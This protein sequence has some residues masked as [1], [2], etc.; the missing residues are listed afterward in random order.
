MTKKLLLAAAA[1]GAMAFAGAATAGSIT[2]GAISGVNITS[3]SGATLKSTP[4]TVATEADMAAAGISTPA[5]AVNVVVGLDS[6]VNLAAGAKVPFA[7]TFTL[8]GPATFEGTLTQA[9]L[10]AANGATAATGLV[11]MSADKKSVTFHIEYEGAAGGSNVDALTLTGA[12]LKVT[13][14]QDVSIA[15][16]A[17][18]TVAGFTQTVGTQAA[19]KIIVFKPALASFKATNYGVTAMLPN[20]KTFGA[21]AANPTGGVATATTVAS[22]QLGLTVN[23]D[24][25]KDL[26]GGAA[27]TLADVIASATAVVKGPQVKTLSATLG[28]IDGTAADTEAKF[29]L[30][31]GE[32]TTGQLTLAQPGTAVAAD[33]GSYTAEIKPVFKAGFS[34]NAD[35]TLNLVTIGLDGTN[36]FAPWFALDTG[37]ANSTLRLANNGSSAIGPIV[38]S[39]KANNGSAAP[40]GTH[41]IPSIAP[42]AFVSVRGDQLKAAFGTDA[43]NG[44]LMITVQSQDNGLSAKVRTTQSTGQIYENSLGTGSQALV[45]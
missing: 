31:A 40:T 15:S 11:V 24:V 29:N 38:I 43:A 36:F 26:A 33:A 39:L 8:T 13:G 34:G 9:N 32:L 4:Y 16:E 19:T 21:Q 44:D 45:D 7:V 27:L 17:R 25:Y 12:T 18:V 42:G 35:A 22:N 10:V 3:G 5:A 23:A 6:P 1:M 2:G 37:S 14:E 28:T 41:T 20:F 30:T